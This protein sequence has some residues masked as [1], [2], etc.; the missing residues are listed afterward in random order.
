VSRGREAR[1]TAQAPG[2]GPT[3]RLLLCPA[4]TSR[5]RQVRLPLP[6]LGQH[7][8]QGGRDAGEP[9]PEL[10]AAEAA[11]AGSE[12]AA[13]SLPGGPLPRR[14]TRRCTRR[15]LGPSTADPPHSHWREA[16]HG[17]ALR[18]AAWRMRA[19][20]GAGHTALYRQPACTVPNLVIEQ[21]QCWT[22]FWRPIFSQQNQKFGR[23]R[24]PFL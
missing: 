13:L 6:L 22:A 4:R 10:R 23:E 16:R 14:S 9:G 19:A 17:L 7:E 2:Q 21:P 1:R 20:L 11:R 24:R 8:R 12:P 18:R 15:T 3:L 5:P